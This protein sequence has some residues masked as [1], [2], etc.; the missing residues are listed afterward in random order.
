MCLE[1]MPSN[2]SD[3]FVCNSFLITRDWSF[4]SSTEKNQ[5]KLIKK[6]GGEIRPVFEE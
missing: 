3:F 5:L 2:A 4:P 1:K 6:R